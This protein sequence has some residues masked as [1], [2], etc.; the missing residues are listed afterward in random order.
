VRPDKVQ[1]VRERIRRLGVEPDVM[2]ALRAML[3]QGDIR[4][5]PALAS[6]LRV[7]LVFNDPDLDGLDLREIAAESFR[8][9]LSAAKRDD[10]S[11]AHV[12]ARITRTIIAESTAQLREEI[13]EAVRAEMESLFGRV[14]G[15]ST[16]TSGR[17]SFPRGIEK[18]VVTPVG[19]SASVSETRGRSRVD[20]ASGLS[21]ARARDAPELLA[22]AASSSR[23]ASCSASITS[24]LN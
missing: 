17:T 11:A 2:G 19:S 1:V 13:P 7:V 9:Q 12:D 3:D 18:A 6:R 10:C 5:V 8:D 24:G 16:P 21:P 14:S 20:Y 23:C 22:Q 15:P 4:I